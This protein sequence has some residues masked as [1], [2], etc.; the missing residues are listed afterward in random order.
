[1]IVLFDREKLIKYR[2]KVNSIVATLE[3]AIYNTSKKRYIEPFKLFYG[4]KIYVIS[5]DKQFNKIKLPDG[6]I[7]FI[8][9]THFERIPSNKKIRVPD[10]CDE[11]KKFIGTPYLW[12]GISSVGLDC[13]GM[14][15]TVLSRFGIK[16]PRDTKDQ[17]KVG[18]KI[19]RNS[20]KTGD[21]LFFDRHVAVALNETDYIHSSI[22]GGGVRINSF[23]NSKTNYRL[24]LDRDFKFARRLSCFK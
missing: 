13:S 17:I 21:L 6:T 10:F 20:I 8:K 15:Q 16:Y 14:I 23:D 11:F 22:G 3:V 12:G 2:K 1:M 7:C 4:T 5:K 9:K 18:R 24:D 19:T